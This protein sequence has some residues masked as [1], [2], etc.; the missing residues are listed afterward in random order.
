MR[1]INKIAESLFEKIRDRFEDV[2]LGNDEANSTLNP[3]DARFFNFDYAVAGKNYGNVT[4]SI[5]DENSLK[6]YFSKNISDQLDDEQRKKWYAFLRELREFAK[7]NL[8]SFEPRDITR[9]TLKQRDIHQ[10][11]KADGTYSKDEVISERRM[12]G[13]SRSSYENTGPVRII[14]R[15]SDNINTEQRGARSRKIRAMYLENSDGERFKLPHHNLKYARAMARHMSEGGTMGDDFA[16]YITQIAEECAKLRPFKNQMARRTFED[17]ETQSMVEAAFEYHSLLNNTLKRM[18]GRR[19]YAACKESFHM[20]Q[21]TIMD[22]FDADSMRERFVKRTYNDKMD[23]ALPLVQKAYKMKKENKFAEQFESWANN[24]AEDWDDGYDSAQLGNSP[25]DVE[26]LADLFAEEVPLGVDG[27]NATAAIQGIIDNEALANNLVQAASQNP[28]ADARDIIMAWVEENEPAVY[29]E[30]VNEIGDAEPADQ[31]VNEGDYDEDSMTSTMTIDQ[32]GNKKWRNQQGQV[33]RTDGPAVEYADGYKAWFLNGELHRKDGPAVEAVS[34]TKIWFLNG[35][36]HRTDGPAVEMADGTKV[37][38]VNDRRHR[39]DGPAIEYPDGRKVYYLKGRKMTKKE[40]AKRTQKSAMTGEGVNEDSEGTKYGVYRRGGSLGSRAG[41]IKTFDTK[42]EAQEYAKRQRK[43]LT[44]GERSYYKMGYT[45]KAVKDEEVNEG[46]SSGGDRVS[47]PDEP[48][49]YWAG[50]GALQDD[51]NRLYD[52]L[53]PSQ[54]KADTIE[55]EVLRA[56]SKIVY[57]HYNDGD[58]FNQASFDQLEPYIGT[59]TSYDDLAHK[60]VEFALKANGNYTPNPDWDSLD[61]MDYGPVDDD[62]DYDD[63]ED[64]DYDDWSDDVDNEEEEDDDEDLAEGDNY[65]EDQIESI[66][67]AIIRRITNNIGQHQELLMKAGPDGVMNA[68]RDVASFHAPVDELG[69]SD[70]S[71]MVREVYNEVGVDFPEL[72]EGRVKELEMDLKELT[73]A[74]FVAKYNKTKQEMKAG[75]SEAHGDYVNKDEKL[76]RA[77]AKP[78]STLD[79]LKMMPK[80]AKA[81]FTGDSEDDLVNYNKSKSSLEEMKRLAG[82]K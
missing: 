22:D 74:E 25:I 19:G 17:Q 34:G 40:W 50:K 77:G 27:A 66:Q 80:Q 10:A 72:A 1:E 68:A 24:V 2:S 60:A 53:V 21:E 36:L 69:S 70:I 28:E 47:L 59:V 42:E 5:V 44:P 45:V 57:R 43:H 56:S 61:A 37:W 15:H 67:T 32:D 39:T 8:L 51:Y 82:L 81:A 35:K 73:D 12:Y 58:E 75:L 20:D 49:T 78:L 54:G 65:D 64:D 4:L 41:L 55:G 13:T 62:D 33:H 79:K 16:Q 71:I 63:E 23:E 30:L 46:W 52:E 18:G 11:S 29:Q 7:R 26:D 48:S 3:E 38:W 76:K 31:T 6:V 14:I 9:S